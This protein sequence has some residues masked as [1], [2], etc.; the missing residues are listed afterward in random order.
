MHWERSVATIA[1]VAR[2]AGGSVSTAWHV[3][4]GTRRVAPNPAHAVEA[5]INSFG[6]RLNIMASRLKATSIRSIMK[7]I[8]KRGL[9]VPQ[10]F[11]VVDF[12][13]FER[14]DCFAPRLILV[15]QSSPEVGRRAIFLLRERIAVPPRSGRTIDL[16][17]A[18][19]ERDCRGRPK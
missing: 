11:S 17:A 4:D 13:D 8:R 2:K 14:A 12:D 18:I 15:A 1:D 6:D 16:D 3:L 7:A 5:A 10:E 9:Q 19:V